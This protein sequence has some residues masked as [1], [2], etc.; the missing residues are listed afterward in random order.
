MIIYFGP[1]DC[2]I[3]GSFL[4]SFGYLKLH[5]IV[6]QFLDTLNYM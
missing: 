6:V 4:Y 2:F 5:V 1:E 3:R